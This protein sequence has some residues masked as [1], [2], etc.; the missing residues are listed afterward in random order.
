MLAG[1]DFKKNDLLRFEKS[2][3]AE[4]LS[5]AAVVGNQIK[6]TH[7][8]VALYHLDSLL[9]KKYSFYELESFYNSLR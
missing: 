1:Y 7:P 6:N 9:L 3:P 5:V 2:D 8:R 4:V